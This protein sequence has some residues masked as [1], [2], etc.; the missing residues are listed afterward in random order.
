M[1]NPNTGRSSIMAVAGGY[2]I[3]IAYEMLKNWIDD[4]PTTMPRWLSA[5]AIA[6]FTGIGITLL[7]YAWKLWRQGRLDQDKNPVEIGEGEKGENGPE[8]P[9]GK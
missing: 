7:V 3:Y 1:N 5:V 6:G 4:I 8:D 2:L 9:D